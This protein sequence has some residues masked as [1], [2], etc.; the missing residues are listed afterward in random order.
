MNNFSRLRTQIAWVRKPHITQHREM[1]RH[2]IARVMNKI[3]SGDELDLI[4]AE[5]LEAR[6][7]GIDLDSSSEDGSEADARQLLNKCKIG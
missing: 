3:A 2:I 1:A 6:S 5:D 4:P 7:S